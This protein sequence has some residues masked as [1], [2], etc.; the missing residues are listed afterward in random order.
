MSHEKDTAPSLIPH[1][2]EFELY[3][4][5]ESLC[6]QMV[7]I[8]LAEKQIAFKGHHIL[9]NEIADEAQNL[10]PAYLAV[11]PQGIVPTLVHNGVPVYDSWEI[12]KYLDR[13]QPHVG[14]RLWPDD[15]SLQHEMD[16]WVHDVSLRDD[17][18]VGQTL[19]TAIPILST[20]IIQRCLKRQSFWRVMWKFRVHPK[21]ERARLFRLLRIVGLP[22]GLSAKAIQTIAISLLSIE[23]KLGSGGPFLLGDFS[24]IDIMLMAHFHRLEDVHLGAV[25]ADAS[26]LPHVS[27]YWAALKARPSYQTAVLDWHEANWRQSIREVWGDA[28]S[29]SLPALQAALRAALKAG[30]TV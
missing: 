28:P 15:P 30:A 10:T 7:R 1:E 8:A 12:I 13:A 5:S 2:A 21:P 25:L 27:A 9:L 11:N 22:K 19:G 16:A 29:P 4:Y 24:Q 26:L 23:R 17:A 14:P 20:P 3:H 18:K 6:A